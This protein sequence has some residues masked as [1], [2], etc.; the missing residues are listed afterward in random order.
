MSPFSVTLWAHALLSLPGGRRQ[1]QHRFR[2]QPLRYYR[3]TSELP[4]ALLRQLAPLI[5]QRLVAAGA[6]VRSE[7]L[8]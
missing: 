3:F 5:E 4:L 7:P 1:E 2:G 6:P 8:G